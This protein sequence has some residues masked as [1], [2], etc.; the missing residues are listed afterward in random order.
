MEKFWYPGSSDS[1]RKISYFS[2]EVGVDSR[3]P[4][5][6]G[7][8]GVLAGDTIKSFADLKVPAVAVTLLSE[9]GYFFQTLDEHGGQL[10]QECTWP[11]AEALNLTDAVVTI[12]AEGRD[13]KVRAWEKVIVSS[14]GFKVP[15]YFLDTNVDGNSEGDRALTAYLYGGDRRYRLLQEMVLGVGGVRILEALGFAAIDHFHMNEGHSSLLILELLRRHAIP[16]GEGEFSKRYDIAAVKRKC[17]FTTHTPI[18]AGHDVFERELARSVIGDYFP[19][20]EMTSCFDHDCFHT[21][22]LALNYS[23]YVNGVAKKH[24]EVTR[25]MFSGYQIDSI[26]NGVHSGTWVSRDFER[27]FDRYIPGWT[28]D[29]FAFRHALSIPD[30]EIWTAHQSA[31]KSLIDLVNSRTDAGMEY[32]VF[33]IGFA[34]RATAYKRPTLIFRNIKKLLDIAR[35]RGKIQLVFGGKAHPHDHSG[36]ALIKDIFGHIQALKGNIAVAFIENYDMEMASYLTSGVDLW[37]NTPMPP[38]EASGTSGMKAAH[39]GIPSLSVLDGW[40]IEGHVEGVTGWSIGGDR[41]VDERPND[42]ADAESM[43]TKLQDEILPLYYAN[44]QAWIRIMK[45]CIALNA[46]FFNTH[47][48]VYQYALSAYL[49]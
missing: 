38:L 10:E 29:P 48:M 49:D 19:F 25:K 13:I 2:M 36:K 18:P 30:E 24:G 4:T 43:F 41:A 16:G 7:G 23:E 32:E 5:Y 22:L 11:V 6:S 14:Q 27:L 46:S 44:K 37:L 17:V 3:I 45:G 12:R 31:K 40:W 9:K 15:I 26:T 35:E 34:R 42:D 1:E 33:T 21:T 8:L 39:N 20:E 28:A 47:R